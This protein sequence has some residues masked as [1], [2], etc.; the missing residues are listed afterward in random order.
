MI[1]KF[2]DKLNA[3][4]LATYINTLQGITVKLGAQN[5]AEIQSDENNIDSDNLLV[6]IVRIEEESTLKN[7]PNKRLI[8]DGGTFKMD[9]R[10]PK[11]HLNYYLLFSCTLQYDKA[12]AVI[13]KTIKFFQHQRKFAF[14]ADEDD[15][16]LNMELCSPSFEQLNNI[17]GMLGGKQIPSVLYKARVSALERDIAQPKPI[18][19]TIG[20]E[21]MHNE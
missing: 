8:E 10:F 21:T 15:I 17:W 13:Y 6:T 1:N 11:I 9:K 12:V 7:F 5:V 2:V 19:T 18:I 14:T 4:G 20:A 3:D 16:E